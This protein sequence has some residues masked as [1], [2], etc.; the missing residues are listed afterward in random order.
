MV[1]LKKENLNN[2]ANGIVLF[3]GKLKEFG[4][5][6]SARV[7]RKVLPAYDC[8]TKDE[9]YSK[10]GAGIL[11]LDGIEKILRDNPANKI[12]KFWTLQIPNPFKFLGGDDKKKGKKVIGRRIAGGCG[13]SGVRD[14]PVLQSDSGRR[15]CRLQQSRYAQDRRSQEKLQRTD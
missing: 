14:R 8:A 3:E 5:V 13:R 12:L 15:S 10:L 1:F 4:I 11:K 6:P 2:I 9:F 7:F